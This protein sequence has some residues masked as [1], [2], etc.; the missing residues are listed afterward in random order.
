MCCPQARVAANKAYMMGLG[1]GPAPTTAAL[2]QQQPWPAA[3]AP[4]DAAVMSAARKLA[5]QAAVQK[6]KRQVSLVNIC[7]CLLPSDMLKMCSERAKSL[8]GLQTLRSYTSDMHA[9]MCVG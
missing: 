7:C 3:L 8:Q 6:A 2:Q 9:C 1:L 4:T 5:Q